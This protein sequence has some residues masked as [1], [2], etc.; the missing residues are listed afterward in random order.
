MKSCAVS[1]LLS[2]LTEIDESV[3]LG[4]FL[5]QEFE[6]IRCT[7]LFFKYPSLRRKDKLACGWHSTPRS[8]CKNKSIH[9]K[10]NHI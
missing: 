2:S 1:F 10:Q 6:Y 9:F 3:F 5:A 4:P 7:A 8:L